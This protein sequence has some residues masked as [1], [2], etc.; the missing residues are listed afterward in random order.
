MLYKVLPTLLSSL[1]VHI[2]GSACW[3]TAIIVLL[4]HANTQPLLLCCDPD[5][6]FCCSLFWHMTHVALTTRR[7]Y[8]PEILDRA[9]NRLHDAR[10]RCKMAIVRSW[11]MLRF[12]TALY[13][14]GFCRACRAAYILGAVMIDGKTEGRLSCA[15]PSHSDVIIHVIADH[16]CK[17]NMGPRIY[18]THIYG[19]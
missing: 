2:S 9:C 17:F 4:V 10:P 5:L 12:S 6:M 11:R 19:M 16:A 13:E 3:K 15:P 1:L 8:A 14:L 18:A 7:A